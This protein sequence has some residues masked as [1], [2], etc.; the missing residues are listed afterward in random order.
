MKKLAFLLLTFLVSTLSFAQTQNFYITG[1]ALIEKNGT[2]QGAPYAVIAHYDNQTFYAYPNAE[3][4]LYTIELTNITPEIG[5][6]FS[7]NVTY[8]DTVCNYHWQNTAVFHWNNSNNQWEDTVELEEFHYSC[9]DNFY[10]V[11]TYNEED[12]HTINFH[13]FTNPAIDNVN[14][15]FGDGNT[16]QIDNQEEIISHTYQQEGEY[17]VTLTGTFQNNTISY[18]QKVFVYNMEEPP[19]DC[20]ADFG[21]YIDSITTDGYYVQFLNFSDAMNGIEGA[22]FEW[23]FGD[24]TTSNEFEPI[25]F[26]SE[27]GEYWVSLRMNTPNCSDTIQLPVWVDNYDSLWVGD[28]YQDCEAIFAP[29]PYYD[30]TLSGYPVQFINLSW[31]GIDADIQAVF[32]DFGDGSYSNEVSPVHVYQDTGEYD[33]H[34]AIETN[35]GCMSEFDMNI[36]VTEFQDTSWVLFYPNLDTSG[37]KGIKVKFH[38]LSGK[39]VTGIWDFGDAKGQTKGSGVVYHTYANEGQYTVTLTDTRTGDVFGMDINVSPDNIEILRTFTREGESSP[40]KVKTTLLSNILKVYPNPANEILNIISPTKETATLNIYS[41]NGTLIKNLT[42]N[43]QKTSID[44]SDLPQGI[45]TLKLQTNQG[46]Y[47]TK[48]VK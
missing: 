15:D 41:T 5:Y 4:G 34:L 24:E 42:I 21:Y 35:H 22:T 11:W 40:S 13:I 36:Q 43:A 6:N 37:G 8:D 29:V 27:P 25:H 14:I 17:D 46:V 7:V 12:F 18:T 26:Y 16:Q 2:V 39:G 30:N 44:I 31:P 32:W 9:T 20:D 23:N 38:D 1:Y 33:V 45:Y 19:I 48:F 28:D 10:F 47:T 3:S